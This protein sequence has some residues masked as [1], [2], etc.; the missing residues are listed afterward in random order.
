MD[1]GKKIEEV[2][3]Q[4]MKRPVLMD[5]FYELESMDQIYEFFSSIRGGYT[6][7][8]FFDYISDF[9]DELDE[10]DEGGSDEISADDLSKVAGGAG[11]TK[12]TLASVLASMSLFPAAPSGLYAIEN[13]QSTAIIESKEGNSKPGEDSKTEESKPGEDSKTEE[14]KPEESKPEENSDK[15]EKKKSGFFSKV[16]KFIFRNKGKI[17]LAI[18]GLVLAAI[19]IKNRKEIAN[20][21]KETLD[22][23]KQMFSPKKDVKL[24]GLSES[25]KSGMTEEQAREVI[26]KLVVG[27]EEE[28]KMPGKEAS[29]EDFERYNAYLKVKEMRNSQVESLVARYSKESGN[30]SWY[31]KIPYFCGIV[32]LLG[33]GKQLASEA[34]DYVKYFS[35]LQDW[36]MN[37]VGPYSFLNNFFRVGRVECDPVTPTDSIS[38]MKKAFEEVKGQKKAKDQIRKA[39]SQIIVSRYSKF[40]SNEMYDHGDVFYFIGPSGV[41][42][43]FMAEKLCKHKVISNDDDFYYFSPVQIDKK[44]SDSLVE[45]IFGPKMS[46]YDINSSKKTRSSMYSYIKN[47]PN[48]V[49]IFD[50]Y[51]KLPD[52]SLDEFFRAVMD[53]GKV[54]VAQQELD[55][56]GI[57]FILTSNESKESL[58]ITHGDT[59]REED[60]SITHRT[61]DKSFTNRLNIVEFEKLSEEDYEEIARVDLH[62]KLRKQYDKKEM[63]GVNITMSDESLKNVAGRAESYK[64]GARY[65]VKKLLGEATQE[66]T[67]FMMNNPKRSF[68]KFKGKTIELVY[69]LRDATEEESKY[70]APKDVAGD[71][72]YYVKVGDKYK[73]WVFEPVLKN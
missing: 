1:I 27:N 44:S 60:D 42:K 38:N 49:V 35:S 13:N 2:F 3:D 30:V 55:C 24:A 50:E 57:T 18:A 45:Q 40:K 39:L 37:L 68:K 73:R 69:K 28:I 52:D 47:H 19:A 34:A 41:G 16:K 61:H 29:K 17:V 56:S 43:T 8:E 9:L 31:S 64:E 48:G 5:E 21:T 65:I 36:L 33:L 11:L 59:E 58:N 51:D 66:L 54:T 70:D 72:R 53:N 15:E 26:T 14:S 6:K 4:I 23:I 46:D 71:G 12:K 7:Q 22:S 62:E 67:E 63:G 10:L 20:W 25:L 32:G